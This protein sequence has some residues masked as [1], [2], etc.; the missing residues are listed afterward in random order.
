MEIVPLS[1]KGT[2]GRGTHIHFEAEPLRADRRT[3]G[4]CARHYLERA[5]PQKSSTDRVAE[6][7]GSV[8]AS[9]EWLFEQVYRPH[10]LQIGADATRVGKTNP[11]RQDVSDTSSIRSGPFKNA[12]RTAEPGKQVNKG[13]LGGGNRCEV[14]RG[15]ASL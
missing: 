15:E 4:W 3:F 9:I 5:H 10:H 11:E 1:E 2:P 8:A 13:P 12:F 14:D 6:I 7:Q